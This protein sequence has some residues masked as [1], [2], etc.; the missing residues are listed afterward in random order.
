MGPPSLV[1]FDFFYSMVLRR[2]YVPPN[3]LT[4]VFCIGGRPGPVNL[5]YSARLIWRLQLQLEITRFPSSA[6]L[7][8]TTEGGWN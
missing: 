5:L 8:P 4:N 6:F 2:V 7:L 1:N 3:G